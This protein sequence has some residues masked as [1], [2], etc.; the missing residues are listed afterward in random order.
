MQQLTET[1]KWWPDF[2]RRTVVDSVK[3]VQP[4]II[5]VLSFQTCMAFFIQWKH[6]SR[7]F[8]DVLELTDFLCVDRNTGSVRVCA[9]LF[10]YQFPN[11]R[12]VPHVC[13][14]C[15]NEKRGQK[16]KQNEPWLVQRWQR[17]LCSRDWF[18]WSRD[19]VHVF[20]PHLSWW[21]SFGQ[22][23]LMENSS[24]SRLMLVFLSDCAV[25]P[26]TRGLI[27]TLEL[28]DLSVEFLISFLV[29]IQC[30]HIH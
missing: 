29:L 3:R 12:K 15:W 13:H 16:W 9:E 26:N 5:V 28:L 19:L 20:S 25:W 24:A 14:S 27:V 2:V 11:K 21:W 10:S 23:Q 8:R 22:Y 4:K 17:C 30:L 18:L 1:L 6:R 7:A